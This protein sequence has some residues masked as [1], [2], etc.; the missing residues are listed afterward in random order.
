MYAFV[1]GAGL[2]ILACPLTPAIRRSTGCSRSAF[3]RWRRDKPPDFRRRKTPDREAMPV[4]DEAAAPSVHCLRPRTQPKP[5]RG[6]VS[7]AGTLLRAAAREDG[8]ENFMRAASDDIVTVDVPRPHGTRQ[9]RMFRQNYKD[10]VA[11][12]IGADARYEFPLP[13]IFAAYVERTAGLVIDVG[14]NTGF[15]ALLACAVRDDGIVLG[16]EPYPDVEYY[17]RQN[18]ELNY[19]QDRVFILPLAISD[20]VGKAN[21]YIPLGNHGLVETSS[22]LEQSFSPEHSK[23]IEVSVS[24]LDTIIGSSDWEEIFVSVLKIDV[25]GHE[26]AVLQGATATI[27]K[28][29]PVIFVEILNRVDCHSLTSFITERG[30]VDFP[31]HQDS[32][33]A[34]DTISF[35]PAAWNHALVPGERV[36][37]FLDYCSPAAQMPLLANGTDLPPKDRRERITRFITPQQKGIEIGPYFQ[38]LAPKRLGYNCLVVDVF[39]AAT[40]RQHALDDPNLPNQI[41]D[42]IEEVDLLGSS[43][44]IAELV[45]ARDR[46]GTFDYIISSH[47]FEHLP[48]PIRFLQGCSKVLRPGGILSMALPDRRTCFDHFRPHSTLAEL[49]DAYFAARDRPTLAQVFE[50]ASLRCCFGAQQALGFALDDDPAQI[51]PLTWLSEAFAQWQSLRTQPDAYHDVHCWTF[52]PASF[53]LI[54]RDLIFLKLISWNVLEISETVGAEFY[55]QLKN[56]AGHT[57]DEVA[58]DRFYRQRRELLFRVN[59]EMAANCAS[60]YHRSGEQALREARRYGAQLEAELAAVRSSTSWRVTAPLRSAATAFR[61]QGRLLAGSRLRPAGE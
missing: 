35:H 7:Q 31:L 22:S 48:D 27:A 36:K 24:T 50:Q 41:T 6:D 49:L 15:Y 54:V 37:E 5:D 10:Q 9:L 29:R 20:K 2:A 11:T 56:R 46:L 60:N 23:V 58:A 26:L 21:L 12:A 34:C 47:S 4:Y 44:A 16:F 52:T 39:D 30:Y 40:L 18:I 57:T 32:L 59:D 61:R 38:P 1:Y 28:W 53:E 17:L 14:I 3:P 45:E 25:E 51:V 8:G 43:S 33:I 55:V 13:E 19:Y 42:E